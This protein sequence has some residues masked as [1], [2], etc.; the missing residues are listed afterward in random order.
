MHVWM[1]SKNEGNLSLSLIE[2]GSPE[3]IA[4]DWASRS[5]YWTDSM[6]DTVEVANLETKQRRALINTKLVNPRGIAVYPTRGLLFW[7]D[8]DRAGP[9]I[10]VAN[11]DGSNR[12][13]FITTALQLPNSL[14]MDYEMEELCWADA[15]LHRIG[16]LLYLFAILNLGIFHYFWQHKEHKVHRKK[17]CQFLSINN[18]CL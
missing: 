13:N 7:S 18:N 1:Q 2:I 11:M 4:I 3:G 16:I 8:W 17:L 10:E 5:I 6:R 9:K 15:G 14:T 12:S